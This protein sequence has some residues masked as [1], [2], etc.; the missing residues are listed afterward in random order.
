[1]CVQP[2][3][4][5]KMETKEMEKAVRNHWSTLLLCF[6]FFVFSFYAFL[7]L[8]QILFFFFVFFGFF[9]FLLLL[10]GDLSSRSVVFVFVFALPLVAAAAAGVVVVAAVVVAAVVVFMLKDLCPFWDRACTTKYFKK[11]GPPRFSHRKIPQES[12]T[13]QFRCRFK[14]GATKKNILSFHCTTG[15]LMGMLLIFGLI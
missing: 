3:A 5:A 8:L 15:C 4:D 13:S 1:M 2:A 9:L 14:N 12:G 6:F 10:L 7:L 11:S